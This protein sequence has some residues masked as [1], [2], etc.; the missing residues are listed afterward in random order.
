MI[1]NAR[2]YSKNLSQ[3]PISIKSIKRRFQWICSSF[4]CTCSTLTVYNVQCSLYS[5]QCSLYS[6]YTVYTSL[7]VLITI[8]TSR[9]LHLYL[10][11]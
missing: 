8:T 2:S 9:D 11:I 10:Q 5:V 6:R 3:S 4:V 7:L 1:I